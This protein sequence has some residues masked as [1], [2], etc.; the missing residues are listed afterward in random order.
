MRWLRGMFQEQDPLVR[1]VAGVS[2]PEALMWRELL[3]NNGIPAMVKN[4]NFLSVAREIGS[5]PWDCDLYVKQSDLERAQEVLAPA[6]G[7]RPPAQPR[8]RRFRSRRPHG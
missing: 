1:V 8:R 5:M 2:E 6:A 4:M 3:E 7:D